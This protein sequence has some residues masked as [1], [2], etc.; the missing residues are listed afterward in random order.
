MPK[1]SSKK[2]PDNFK[3]YIY[4][5]LGLSAVALVSIW[6]SGCNNSK[7]NTN[8]DPA[9]DFNVEISLP[10]DKAGN[11]NAVPKAEIDS[12]FNNLKQ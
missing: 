11:I 9:T 3:S 10:K 6:I 12:L 8:G 4:L 1:K 2:S 5:G 7:A